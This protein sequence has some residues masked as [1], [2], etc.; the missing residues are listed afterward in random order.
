[1]W[2]LCV[3]LWETWRGLVGAWI[4]WY[5]IYHWRRTRRALYTYS[6]MRSPRS[7]SLDGVWLEAW[8]RYKLFVILSWVDEIDDTNSKTHKY[9]Y[10]FGTFWYQFVLFFKHYS[11]IEIEDIFDC[12][13]VYIII[14][15]RLITPSTASISPKTAQVD[16]VYYN[17]LLSL[18][19]NPNQNQTCHLQRLCATAR[20]PY[21]KPN[22]RRL[23]QY[24]VL[25]IIPNHNMHFVREPLHPI[26]KDALMLSH[27]STFPQHCFD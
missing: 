3:I 24:I 13:V 15:L 11:E 19:P 12:I 25:F 8:W 16:V 1:M 4:Y 22:L 6:Y 26:Y 2:C 9:L 17:I 21:T 18:V 23:L 5:A 20:F 27:L 7:D 10:D 14:H